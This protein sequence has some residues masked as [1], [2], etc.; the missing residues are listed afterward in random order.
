M[1]TLFVAGSLVLAAVTHRTSGI[2]FALVAVPLLSLA[3]GPWYAASLANMGGMLV[4][5]VVMLQ[6]RRD[7]D[8]KIVPVISTVAVIGCI[9]GALLAARLNP[10]VL[11]IAIGLTLLVA[12]TIV[13]LASRTRSASA[14]RHAR[15]WI[16]S[17]AFV[18]GFMNASAALGGPALT[19]LA[20]VTDWKHSRFVASIQPAFVLMGLMTI[21]ARS[22]AR[23]DQFPPTGFGEIASMAIGL[24][25]GLAAGTWLADRIPVRW[26]R[27]ITFAIAYLGAVAALLRGVVS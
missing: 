13:I 11:G 24:L 14:P 1:I 22:I 27:R 5:T 7:I 16:P 8:W 26:A 6:L 18:S 10:K 4:A 19:V 9:P 15:I 17:L 20:A 3:I 2:G 12:I 23:D 25:I 21:F